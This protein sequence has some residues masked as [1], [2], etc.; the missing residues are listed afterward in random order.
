MFGCVIHFV[1]CVLG[2]YEKIPYSD[3]AIRS[4]YHLRELEVYRMMHLQHS[5]THLDA[6]LTHD[7]PNYVWEHGDVAALLRIKPFFREDI[8]K[9]ALGSPPGRQILDALMP[10][11]WFSG[12]LH[13]KFEAV[14]PHAA[15]TTSSTADASEAVEAAPAAAIKTTRFLAL[16]KVIPGRPYLQFLQI[17]LTGSST[18][19]DDNELHYDP[20]W[21][22]IVVRT[23]QELRKSHFKYPTPP[24][25]CS[26]EV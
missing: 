20:E 25:P 19:Y 18:I 6:F 2:H 24:K 15:A 10:S 5:A 9:G 22:S 23:H 4:I 13:V 16:D 17:P 7:W 21:L 11:F 26:A 12:H 1:K 14:V 3:G 8:D